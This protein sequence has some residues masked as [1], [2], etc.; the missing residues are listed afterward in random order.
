MPEPGAREDIHEGSR[1]HSPAS[2]VYYQLAGGAQ[3]IIP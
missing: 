1:L 3:A 2:E